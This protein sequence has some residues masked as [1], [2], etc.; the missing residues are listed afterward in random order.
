MYWCV[1]MCVCIGVYIKVPY[2]SGYIVMYLY[3]RL[4]NVSILTLCGYDSFCRRFIYLLYSINIYRLLMVHV[5][6]PICCIERREY[7]YIYIYTYIKDF[8]KEC[9]S[10]SLRIYTTYTYTCIIHYNHR[11]TRIPHHVYHV[12]ITST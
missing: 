7:I 4:V 6:T 8:P 3:N 2:T 1:C 5:C 10:K 11:Y 12:Y 9:F